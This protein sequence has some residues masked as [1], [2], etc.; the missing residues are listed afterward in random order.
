MSTEK[1][2]GALRVA[3]QICAIIL[4]I[5]LGTSKAQTT[6]RRAL[7]LQQLH[8]SDLSQEDDGLHKAALANGGSYTSCCLIEGRSHATS[9]NQLC[10]ASD[11]IIIG[12]VE[13]IEPR[14]QDNGKQIDT[15]YT[16]RI[17][18]TLK[19]P[20][21]PPRI[22]NYVATGGTFSFQDGSSATFQARG[23]VPLNQGK[24]Y[25]IFAKQRAHSANEWEAISQGQSVLELSSDG[26][27]AY[28]H[29]H[30]TSDIMRK[31]AQSGTSVLVAKI[32]AIVKTENLDS[33]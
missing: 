12:T 27:R 23:V 13:T 7:A 19:G 3:V 33:K 20:P 17:E 14:L 2:L 8:L 6:D 24:K 22:L 5:N 1:R 25:I 18:Q 15:T 26:S 28:S 9:L 10:N 21:K 31:E 30:D 11:I 16:I 4:L 32:V 29:A